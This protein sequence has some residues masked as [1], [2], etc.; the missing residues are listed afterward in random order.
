MI[1]AILKENPVPVKQEG[2]VVKFS[3]RKPEQSDISI[4][5]LKSLKEIY[6]FIRM[7]DAEGYPKAF[8]KIDNIK[9]EFSEAKLHNGKLTGKFEVISE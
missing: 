9:I 7:L 1:P 2:K 5:T 3:R 6:D 8:L 4:A